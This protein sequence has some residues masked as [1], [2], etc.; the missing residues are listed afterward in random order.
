MHV[1]KGQKKLIFAAVKISNNIDDLKKPFAGKS[2]N[3]HAV[4]EDLKFS[5]LFIFIRKSFSE[6]AVSTRVL[7]NE[8]LATRSFHGDD[9]QVSWKIPSRRHFFIL[10]SRLKLIGNRG[11]NTQSTMHGYHQKTGVMFFA[12]I[13][14]NAVTCWN[15]KST[16]RPSNMGEVARDN[17]TLVYP[18]DLN[19]R[20]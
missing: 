15:S 14:K 12:E 7:R 9:I 19:V 16:L 11:E 4:L 10:F 1:Q 5:F 8:T 17:V 20:F 3:I 18:S 2:R 13:N 6:F